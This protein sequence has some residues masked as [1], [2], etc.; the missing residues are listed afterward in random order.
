M[1][2][3]CR[4]F[5]LRKP[6]TNIQILQ[7]NVMLKHKLLVAFMKKQ[8]REVFSEVRMAYIDTLSKVLSSHFRAYLGAVERLE[9]LAVFNLPGC[10]NRFLICCVCLP[11]VSTNLA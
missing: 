2:C 9:V 1:M 10:F 11:P 7:Q 3:L 6:K 8:G 4:I 5:A